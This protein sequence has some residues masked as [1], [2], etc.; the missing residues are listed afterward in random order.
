MKEVADF[1][2]GTRPQIF[3]L[4]KLIVD[5]GYT[6]FE[7]DENNKWV[8]SGPEMSMVKELFDFRE[9]NSLTW[10]NTVEQYFSKVE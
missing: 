8:L 4:L 6:T 3:K 1:V 5:E 7:T 2:G 9:K 10:T